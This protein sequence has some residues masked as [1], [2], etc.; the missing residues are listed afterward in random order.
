VDTITLRP[1]RNQDF[2][3]IIAI[4][5][6]GRP[7]VSLL[8]PAELAAIKL[9]APLFKIAERDRQLVGY[10]IAY[11]DTN[12]YDGEEFNWFK[13]RFTHFLYID[14][15]AIAQ[16]AQRAGLGGLIYQLLEQHARQ[17]GLTSLTCE[18]N[19][20]PANPVSLAFHTRQRFVEI[21]TLATSDGRTV[22]L[23]RK[24]LG[25]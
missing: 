6:A 3:R 23:R 20:E 22:S 11:V 15:I 18:V 12:L 24:E 16:S 4:N 21:G 13:Q 19:L 10:V 1:A 8:T 14:Q 17:R 7:G 5:A 2:E 9:D 25:E